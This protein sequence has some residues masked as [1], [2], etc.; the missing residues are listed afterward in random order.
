M[1]N[2]GDTP[3][4]NVYQGLLDQNRAASQRSEQGG[5]RIGSGSLKKIK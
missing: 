2:Q 3:K 4:S 5:E 1:V